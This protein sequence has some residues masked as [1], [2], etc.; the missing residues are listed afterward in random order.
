LTRVH[1]VRIIAFVK[2]SALATFVRR[3]TTVDQFLYLSD[4][5][6]IYGAL[7]TK[8]QQECLHLHL[9]D[10]FSLSEIGEEL[11]ISRQAVY[12]NIHRAEKAMNGYEA[13]LGL[14]ARYR[15]ERAT[16]QTI[17]ERVEGLRTEANSVAIDEIRTSLAPLLGR[18]RE[19]KEEH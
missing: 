17:D 9:Y 4:L 16:L 12:D 5:Y 13:K 19:E 1:G 18:E 7:L 8:K 14:A 6:D 11:G 3:V 15:S 2:E 10:D